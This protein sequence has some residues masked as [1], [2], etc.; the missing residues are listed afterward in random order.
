MLHP[1]KTKLQQALEDHIIKCLSNEPKYTPLSDIVLLMIITNIENMI[2]KH[3]LCPKDVHIK[4]TFPYKNEILA[5]YY[6][7]NGSSEEEINNLLEKD[8]DNI[9]VTIIPIE[10]PRIL[11]IQI[12]PTYKGDI[13]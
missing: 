8:Y 1:R 6:R 13:R 10:K 9:T 12:I 4:V 5:E 3:R 2:S 11:D 7:N